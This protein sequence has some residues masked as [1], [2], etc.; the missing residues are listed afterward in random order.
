M[1]SLVIGAF[2]HRHLFG[3]IFR[4]G[5]LDE[6][7]HDP[8]TGGVAHGAGEAD[9]GRVVVDGGEVLPFFEGGGRGSLVLRHG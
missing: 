8:P 3:Q 5:N 4:N 2:T 7:P 1:Q 6:I 9:L